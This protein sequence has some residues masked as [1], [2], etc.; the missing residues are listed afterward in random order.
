MVAALKDLRSSILDEKDK[1]ANTGVI[2]DRAPS[3]SSL[4]SSITSD[5]EDSRSG[6]EDD[7]LQMDKDAEDDIAEFEEQ[8]LQYV[9]MV[10]SHFNREGLIFAHTLQLVARKF[11]T[12]PS[13][14]KVIAKV[15]H[16][17]TKFNKSC[18]ATEKLIQLSGK[19]LIANC[20]TRWS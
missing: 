2:G 20:P 3:S 12:F 16:L 13:V 17:L 19:K 1:V 4:Q 6:D 14:K 8:E 5:S 7:L 18:K 9:L 11:D 10:S 15:Y